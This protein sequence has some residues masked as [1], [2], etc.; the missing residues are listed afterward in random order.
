MTL[1][2]AA[3]DIR[4]RSTSSRNLPIRQSFRRL[5]GFPESLCL[6][7]IPASRFWQMR[8]F[9]KGKLITRSTRAERLEVAEAFAK[10]IFSE[11]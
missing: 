8:V 11:S 4:F 3:N 1:N 7:K 2:A 6:Y 5:D 9:H 10:R